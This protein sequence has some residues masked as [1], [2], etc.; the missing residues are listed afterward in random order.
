MNRRRRRRG[1]PDERGSI[2]VWAVTI[3]PAMI[4]LAGLAVDG[5]GKVHAEQ[6]AM[7]LAAEAAR[8]GGQQ[9][10][11]D[12][13]VHGV[14][15]TADIARARAA[16]QTYLAAAHVAGTVRFAGGDTIR[17][18]VSDS[19][20]P[21]FLPIVGIDRLTVTGDAEVRGVRAV[22]GEER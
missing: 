17:V 20:E 2:S 3:A 16:A 22:D 7:Q 5:G 12:Q 15:A 6:R 19:Y 8:V 4:I 14:R 9:L 18:T 10:H 11:L 13:A 21:V 1:T